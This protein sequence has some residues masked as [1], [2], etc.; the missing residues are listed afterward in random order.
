[1][2]FKSTDLII[3]IL[4]AFDDRNSEIGLRTLRASKLIAVSIRRSEPATFT[5]DIDR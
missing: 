4:G 2:P 1:M 5:I 3:D